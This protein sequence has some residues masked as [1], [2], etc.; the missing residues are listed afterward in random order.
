MGENPTCGAASARRE[1][2]AVFSTIH[3]SEELN[4]I[5]TNKLLFN[6]N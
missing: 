1:G 6:E 2:I 3:L 5:L 4:I